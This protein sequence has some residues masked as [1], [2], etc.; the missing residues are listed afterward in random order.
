MISVK[1]YGRHGIFLYR[2]KYP[3]NSWVRTCD[4]HFPPMSTRVILRNLVRLS[5]VSEGRIF[6]GLR[7]YSKALHGDYAPVDATSAGLRVVWPVARSSEQNALKNACNS[8]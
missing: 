5:N 2:K 4:S 7:F 8:V 6:F 1:L 3:Y